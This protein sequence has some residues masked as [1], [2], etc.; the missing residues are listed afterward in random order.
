M[1]RTLCRR[2]WLIARSLPLALG[3][4]AAAGAQTTFNYTGS[5]Q[6]Y[7]LPA[8]ASGVLMQAAGAGGGGGGADDNGPG[9]AGGP[10]AI[11]T[12]VYLTA[13]GSSLT[14]YVGGGGNPGFTSNF[15]RNCTSSAGAGGQSGGVGG[16][17][18]GAGGQAGC[19]G[20]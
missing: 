9:S 5:V 14:V 18:G 8:G 10:G 4:A 15:G 2:L 3:L 6:T 20:W 16:F 17:A 11:A 7:V 19:P 12:G 13:G 1:K